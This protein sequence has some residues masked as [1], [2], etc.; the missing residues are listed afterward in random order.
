MILH[1]A[2]SQGVIHTRNALRHLDPELR[3][4][5]VV[6]A[7]GPASYISDDSCFAVHHLASKRDIVPHID[8]KGKNHYKDTITWLEPHP[9]A[10]FFDHVFQSPTYSEPMKERFDYYFSLFGVS[11]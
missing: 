1:F 9:D 5:I 10:P 7:V 11:E 4:Q 3:K 2:F 8:F 6:I